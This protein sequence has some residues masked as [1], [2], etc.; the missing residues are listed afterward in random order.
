M[1]VS[2]SRKRGKRSKDRKT[3]SI[4]SGGPGRTQLHKLTQKLGRI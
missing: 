4:K 2:K 3:K 1:A